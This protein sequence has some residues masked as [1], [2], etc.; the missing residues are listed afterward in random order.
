MWNDQYWQWKQ[1][2]DV[3]DTPSSFFHFPLFSSVSIVNF[4]QI[5]VSWDKLIEE[6]FLEFMY[7]MTKQ[8]DEFDVQYSFLRFAQPT[9]KNV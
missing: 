2:N 5:N 7:K 8:K 6:T 3:N 9:A 1:Q 4:E